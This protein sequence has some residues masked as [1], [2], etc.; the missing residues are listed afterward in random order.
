MLPNI[1]TQEE[2]IWLGHRPSLPHS[3][4]VLGHSTKSKN[5]IYAFGHQHL[6]MTLAAITGDIIADLLGNKEPKVSVFPYRV[7]KSVQ[8]I[9]ND[10]GFPLY[11]RY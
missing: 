8:Y 3:L 9:M 2:S 7:N 5:V 10:Y 6:G 11:L 4:P 1:E